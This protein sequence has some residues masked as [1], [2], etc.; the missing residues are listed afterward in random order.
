[1]SVLSMMNSPAPPGVGAS[2]V[3]KRLPHHTCDACRQVCPVQAITFTVNAVMLDDASCIRCGHCLFA[4]P[5]DA[6]ENLNAAERKYRDASL[7]AP[8][9]TLAAGVDELLMWHI[10]YT[11]RAVELNIDEYPAWALAVA[12][13]N[14]RLKALNEPLWQI[15]PPVSG[16]V[17]VFRRHLLR[18]NE[19]RARSARV[20]ASQRLRRN[21]WQAYGEHQLSLN[22][23]LCILCGACER[24]CEEKAITFTEKEM[25]LSSSSC[26]GCNNCAIACPTKAIKTQAKVGN[27]EVVSVSYSQRICSGCQREFPTL[28]PDDKQCPICQRHEFGMR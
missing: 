10:Q 25:V 18:F 23:S 6:L 11:I 28:N 12:A 20:K 5:V 27:C 14:I 24:I 3:R 13:L 15:I 26:T 17:N 22:E 9:S 8:F 1:M 2:C 7:V 21:V 16:R 4:C 19:E